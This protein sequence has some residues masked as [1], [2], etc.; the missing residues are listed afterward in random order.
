MSGR[1]WQVRTDYLEAIRKRPIRIFVSN[2][3]VVAD[4]N[5]L[6]VATIAIREHLQSVAMISVIINVYAVHYRIEFD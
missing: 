1:K 4:D 5:V 6:Q 3:L 2:E